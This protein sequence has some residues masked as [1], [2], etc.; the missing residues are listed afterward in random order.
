MGD[1]WQHQG[2]HEGAFPTLLKALPPPP[3]KRKNVKISHFWIFPLRNVFCPLNTPHKKFSGAATVGENP[4]YR[5]CVNILPEQV[6]CQLMTIYTQII[7]KLCNILCNNPDNF[8]TYIVY[9]IK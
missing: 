5:P 4:W 1:Q 2:G 9:F 6:C 3:I 8:N 7:I